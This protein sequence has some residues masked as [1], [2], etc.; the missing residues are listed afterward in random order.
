MVA[1]ARKNKRVVQVGTRS[2]VLVAQ[3]AQTP[4][5]PPQGAGA[6][7]PPPG[8]ELVSS[9]RARGPTRPEPRRPRFPRSTARRRARGRDARRV[10]RERA[11][12]SL[13]P[14]RVQVGW[15]MAYH[16][17]SLPRSW[18][19]VRRRTVGHRQPDL[20]AH[21]GNGC[22]R[23]ECFGSDGKT[24]GLSGSMRAEVTK[25]FFQQYRP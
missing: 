4:A 17:R 21:G 11:I 5:A 18:H 7:A 22:R 10:F 1:A 15:R 6:P 25:C 20:G 16:H 3:T 14:L 9:G 19:G 2:P 24:R 8:D 13:S 23:P 12:R